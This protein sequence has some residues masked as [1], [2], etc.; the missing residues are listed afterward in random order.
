MTDI[1]KSK[2]LRVQ[3][4]ACSNQQVLYNKPA[5]KVKCLACGKTLANST[6]GEAEVLGKIVEVLE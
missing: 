3:C 5:M 4:N 1:P 6:G 2:F